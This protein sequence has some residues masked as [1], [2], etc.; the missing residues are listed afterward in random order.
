M[1][2]QLTLSTQLL[3]ESALR[4]VVLVDSELPRWPLRILAS[5]AWV[6]RHRHGQSGFSTCIRTV[7][8][9]LR[10]C[11]RPCGPWLAWGPC[12]RCSLLMSCGNVKTAVSHLRSALN[13]AKGVHHS[14]R[15]AKA[16][17]KA[18]KALIHA[19]GIRARG[20]SPLG[21]SAGQCGIELAGFPCQVTDRAARPHPGFVGLKDLRR[22]HNQH[23]SCG[24]HP[25]RA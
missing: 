1:E 8:T 17:R 20:P 9:A 24:S 13:P 25:P 16:I 18:E 15:L 5:D 12:C 11:H 14:H 23:R 6:A 2:S 21:A 19:R 22:R 7:L 10:L 4:L 3:S